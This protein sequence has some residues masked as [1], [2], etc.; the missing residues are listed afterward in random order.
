MVARLDDITDDVREIKAV[1][2]GNGRDGL[3]MKVDR[4][5]QQ[6]ER[7]RISRT[8]RVA[9]YVAALSGASLLVNTLVRHLIGA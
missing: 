8:E 4:L 2:F 5:E 6:A 7:A 1:V 9:L 3:N